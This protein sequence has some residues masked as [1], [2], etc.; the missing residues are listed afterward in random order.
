MQA[1]PV[2]RPLASPPQ[3]LL[4]DLSSDALQPAPRQL[5]TASRLGSI[6]PGTRPATRRT[7]AWTM[8]HGSSI[9]SV[10]HSAA[11]ASPSLSGAGS[12]CCSLERNDSR[13]K[14]AFADAISADFG[15]R[16]HRNGPARNHGAALADPP[17]APAVSWWMQPQ[18]GGSRPHLLAR[19]RL[20]AARAARRRRHRQPRG[21]I[22]CSSRSRRWSTSLAA[23]NRADHQALR[24]H[25]AILRPAEAARRPRP[26][27]RTTSPSSLGGADV[28]ARLLAGCPSTI[29]SSP[30]PPPSAAR[31]LPPRR[32]TCARRRWSSAASR[33]P[34]SARR[35]RS[36]KAVKRHRLWQVRQCRPDLHR[37]GL[38]ARARASRAIEFAEAVLAEARRAYPELSPRLFHA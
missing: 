28:A 10:L 21:T 13:Q 14:D 19:R 23:G 22:R 31:S 3:A 32:K 20:G 12:R 4:Q 24:A 1:P 27:T 15:N 6:R 30:A 35:P 16:S 38:C 34:S 25:A 18:R 17:C 33:R 26:S 36:S 37:A 7:P 8:Q 9:S 2:R 5:E 29:S 11:R